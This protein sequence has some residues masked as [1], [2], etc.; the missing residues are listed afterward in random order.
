[1]SDYELNRLIKTFLKHA[2]EQIER[3]DEQKKK[4]IEQNPNEPV[5][6]HMN[7]EFN[8]PYALA[9]MCLEINKL[10]VMVYEVD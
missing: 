1:M 10:K 4:Y 7:E 9:C 5:P 8:L 2:E 3:N 6:D